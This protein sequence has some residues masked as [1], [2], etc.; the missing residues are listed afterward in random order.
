CRTIPLRIDGIGHNTYGSCA[1]D[2]VAIPASHCYSTGK[3][4]TAHGAARASTTTPRSTSCTRC[5][6]KAQQVGPLA[7]LTIRRWRV[8]R[9]TNEQ[10]SMQEAVLHT[11]R[12]LIVDDQELNVRLLERILRL[13]GY[14]QIQGTT[15]P[16]QTLTLFEAFQ[17]DL[18]LLDLRM[19]LMDG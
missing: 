14:S 15:D 16:H 5:T 19:P 12:I 11:A 18:M 4:E 7:P 1:V 6:G 8:W 13:D 3:S 2:V 17:P 10:A 9:L